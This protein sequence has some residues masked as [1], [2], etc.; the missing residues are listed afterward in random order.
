ME[1]ESKLESVHE[2][3]N[4]LEKENERLANEKSALEKLT[5]ALHTE[6]EALKKATSAETNNYQEIHESLTKVTEET[7]LVIVIPEDLDDDKYVERKVSGV[8]SISFADYAFQIRFGSSH[9]PRCA[10]EQPEAVPNNRISASP[11]EKATNTN[12]VKMGRRK[13]H[14]LKKAGLLV[15]DLV[16]G[17]SSNPSVI[18]NLD[19]NSV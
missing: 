13:R 12:T 17:S 8:E 1:L 5:Q 14:K 7:Q 10:H 6:N 4:S 15:Q 19:G 16:P 9:R 11:D 2:K 3:C 18:N